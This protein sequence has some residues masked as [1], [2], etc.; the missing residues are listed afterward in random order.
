MAV[1]LSSCGKSGLPDGRYEPT[2]AAQAII[3]PAIVV[4]GKNFSVVMPMGIGANN[5]TYKYS[6]G[7]VTLTDGA[8]LS[9]SIACTYDADSE[10]LTYGGVECKKTD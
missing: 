8:G 9:G 10:I 2:D 6:K 4:E 5:F 7:T 1:L 3:I